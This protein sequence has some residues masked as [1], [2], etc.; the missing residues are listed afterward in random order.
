MEKKCIKC[1]CTSHK[2]EAQFCYYCGTELNLFKPEKCS[3]CG[4]T[5]GRFDKFCIKCGKPYP[6]ADDEKN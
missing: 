1:G 6:E 5:Q 2:N 4:E 3:V